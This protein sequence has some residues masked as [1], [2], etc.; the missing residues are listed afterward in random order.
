M[1]LL[2]RQLSCTTPSSASTWRRPSIRSSMSILAGD[3]DAAFETM[4]KH[5][6]DGAGGGSSMVKSGGNASTSFNAY[7]IAWPACKHAGAAL[8]RRRP[9]R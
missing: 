2:N 4:H 9:C 7:G 6:Q 8:L 3:E 5:I 1:L